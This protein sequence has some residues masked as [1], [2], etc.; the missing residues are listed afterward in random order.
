VYNVLGQL[1]KTVV[2]NV[3]QEPA[4]YTVNV[5]MSGLNS[6]VYVYVLE[7]GNRRLSQKMML[8]K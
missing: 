6:G 3:H 4:R 2:D 7:Q 5:D 1:V 8:L